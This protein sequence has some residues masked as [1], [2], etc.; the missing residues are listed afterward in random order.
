MVVVVLLLVVVSAVVLLVVVVLSVVA[1]VG[2]SGCVGSTFVFGFLC[3]SPGSVVSL[4]V[5]V[6]SVLV[7]VVGGVVPVDVVVLW[8]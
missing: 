5:F 1:F 4:V 7:V 3:L 8:L 6:G 2:S